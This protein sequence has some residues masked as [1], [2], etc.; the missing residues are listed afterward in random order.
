MCPD[1]AG[2]RLFIQCSARYTRLH[3]DKLAFLIDLDIMYY[4][5]VLSSQEAEMNSFQDMLFVIMVAY[6]FSFDETT[7]DFI[8]SHKTFLEKI[9]LGFYI[10]YFLAKAVLEFRRR[11][12]TTPSSS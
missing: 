9:F 3:L 10:F 11:K 7:R 6:I 1:G 5:L 8:I 2:L 12:V 4:I